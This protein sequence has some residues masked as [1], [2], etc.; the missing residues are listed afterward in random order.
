MKKNKRKKNRKPKKKVQ[1]VDWR[2]ES[3]TDKQKNLIIW[4]FGLS[5]KDVENLNKGQASRLID[6]GNQLLESNKKLSDVDWKQYIKEP[7]QLNKEE[8][9]L[10]DEA[11]EELRENSKEENKPKKFAS[12]KKPKNWKAD[13]S[14]KRLNRWT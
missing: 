13:D 10:L 14:K 2:K 8:Q 5:K 12:P 6:K 3:A 4:E 9:Q 11:Y 7:K 1:K